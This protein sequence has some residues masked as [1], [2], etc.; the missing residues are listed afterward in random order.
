MG[1][2]YDECMA[3]PFSLLL[4]LIAIQQIKKEGAKRKPSAAGEMEEFERL[5]T[6][7]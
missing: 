7:K 5:L 6:F 4:D 2:S 1:L 3:V